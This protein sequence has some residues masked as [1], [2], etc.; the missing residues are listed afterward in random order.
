MN[1][2]NL[3]YLINRSCGDLDYGQAYNC[4]DVLFGG[5]FERL[6]VINKGDIASVAYSA[7]TPNLITGITLKSG[8]VMH[9]FE[10]FRNSIIPSL[11]AVENASGPTLWKHTCN[12]FV[13]S[14]TQLWK[15]QLEKFGRGKYVT[16]FQNLKENNDAFEV[17]GLGRGLELQAG[18]VNNKNENN[19]AYN[20]ILASR[21][22]QEEVR[23]PQTFLSTDFA[24]TVTAFETLAALPTITNISDLAL[25][26]A[27][28]DSETITGTG[29]YGGGS[30]ADVQSIKWVNQSTKAKTSQASFTVVS[31]TSIT[32]TSVAL[33]AGTYKLEITTSRG[34][35]T[36]TLIAT[37]S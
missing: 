22:G 26:V 12:F 11:D 31:N 28:G 16:I 24:G 10:G 29:F 8:K 15:N 35:A 21:A 36:S 33:V 18:T 25:Q 17:Q 37:A 32:F 19:G 9:L 1:F 23:P 20:L 34:V 2:L 5:V 3:P 27:G 30:A 7:T 14:N 6:G 13:F 4:D